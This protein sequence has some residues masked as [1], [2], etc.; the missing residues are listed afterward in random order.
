MSIR[1][2]ANNTIGNA[3]DTIA[4]LVNNAKSAI[5]NIVGTASTGI[6]NL[7]SGGFVGMSREGMEQLNTAV[8]NYCQ[9]IEEA[10]SE[11]NDEA[12]RA[13]AYAGEISDA[14][15]EYVEGM[16]KM[17]SAYVSTMRTNQEEA[18]NAFNTFHSS[19]QSISQDVTSDAGDIKSNA[20]SIRVES[21]K[22]SLE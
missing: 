13:D 16:K 20:E 19:E 8:E 2:V 18:A 10:I 3:G 15:H 14:V 1:S 17:L 9:T 12:S 7:Y 22:I 11:F 4:T 5:S 21:S 6:G